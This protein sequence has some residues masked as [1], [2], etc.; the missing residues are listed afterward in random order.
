M[1]DVWGHAYQI[2]ELPPP[3]GQPSPLRSTLAM[4]QKL[5]PRGTVKRIVK[6]HSNRNLSKNADI[7]VRRT[8]P[9]RKTSLTDSVQIFLDYMLFLQEYALCVAALQFPF[10]PSQPAWDTLEANTVCR[11]M[12]EASIK[13]RKSGEKNISANTVRKVTE[14]CFNWSKRSRNSQD[15]QLTRLDSVRK[16][17]ASSRGR[18]PLGIS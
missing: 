7:L 2:R 6:A 15:N 11:L 17:C 9:T 12:R 3:S 8:C 16:H 14:V 1:S 5:Y 4:A 18:T 13:S 10:Q